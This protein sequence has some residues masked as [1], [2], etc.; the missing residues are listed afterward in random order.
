M[1]KMDKPSVSVIILSVL[2][3]LSISFSALQYFQRYASK[4]VIDREKL[5]VAVMWEI[6]NGENKISKDEIRDI[7][8]LKS[9]AGVYPY[10]YDVAINLKNGEQILYSWK[11]K[12][13]TD[14]EIINIR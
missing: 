5:L 11:D 13:Q 3:V 12:N 8:V 6:N 9:K 4:D 14:V 2:L 10:Y 7:T 1:K